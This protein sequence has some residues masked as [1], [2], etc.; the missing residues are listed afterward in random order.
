MGSWML[1]PRECQRAGQDLP[2]G[3]RLELDGEHGGI[4]DTAGC[5]GSCPGKHGMEVL[6]NTRVSCPF[7]LRCL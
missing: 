3:Q 4:H 5:P 7:L 1:V 2:L 6:A